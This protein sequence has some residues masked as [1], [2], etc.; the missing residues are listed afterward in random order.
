MCGLEVFVA[1]LATALGRHPGALLHIKSRPA[2]KIHVRRLYFLK[3]LLLGVYWTQNLGE[4]M[5]FS[6]VF[7]LLHS[8]L[9]SVKCFKVFIGLI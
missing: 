7:F 9:A 5:C 2:D 6:F 3:A 8:Y 1:S 4:F